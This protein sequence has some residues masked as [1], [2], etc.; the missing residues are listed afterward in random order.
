MARNVGNSNA[1]THGLS[2][3]PVYAAWLGMRQRC[4]N[5]RHAGYKN[6]GG[7]GIK[8]C[9]RWADFLTFY[10]DMSPTYFPKASLDRANNDDDYKPSNCHWITKR[11]QNANK[12]NTPPKELIAQLS[13][14]GLS[15]QNYKS[16]LYKGW[17][18]I[19]ALTTP[20][21]VSRK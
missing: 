15:W 1:K 14:I 8:I 7:R 3:H 9:E 4:N 12:Q 19:E 11:M 17:T 10:A 21:G 6:W 5:P 13:S 18:E 20:K 16:R 2:A